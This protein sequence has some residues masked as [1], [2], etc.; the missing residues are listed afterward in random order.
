MTSQKPTDL[1]EQFLSDLAS[2][3]VDAALAEVDEQIVYTNVGLPTVRGK[4]RFS[5]VMRGLNGDFIGFDAQML[6]IAADEAGVV[7]TERI[8]ELRFGPLRLRFWVCG[9][10]EVI[11]GRIAVWRDYFD[12]FDCT[13]AAVRALAALVIPSL[14]RPLDEPLS[15]R[16]PS[17]S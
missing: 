8:D 11:E 2:G 1:V 15:R 9:R 12:V 7:L 6:A 3:R 16:E 14:Q 4:R 13:K 5:S 10:F 17:L